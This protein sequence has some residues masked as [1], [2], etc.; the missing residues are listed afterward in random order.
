MEYLAQPNLL[1]EA[2]AY[3]GRETSGRSWA[4]IEQRL[5]QHKAETSPAFQRDFAALKRATARIK[6]ELSRHPAPRPELF[7]DLEGFPF[8]TIGSSSI[9]FLLFYPM[10]DRYDGDPMAVAEAVSALA[11]EQ[12]AGNLLDTLDIAGDRTEGDAVSGA[13]LMDTVLSLSVPDQSKITI[14]HIY[15]NYPAL[16]R[17]TAAAMAPLLELLEREMPT[18]LEMTAAFEADMRAI[19]RED[20]FGHLTHLKP[21]PEVDYLIRPFIF[22]MDTNLTFN[23]APNSVHFYCGFLRKELLH[24]ISAQSSHSDDVYASYRLLGDRT[25]FDILCYLRDHVAYGQELSDRF[26]LSR[27]TIHHHMNKLVDAGLVSCTV[28]GNRVYYSLDREAV[29]TFLRSQETLFAGE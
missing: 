27:N 22:G 15:R 28:S 19:S 1:L 4:H 3:Y 21:A 5:R 13:D 11:P 14:L 16:A 24:V 2:L 9:A 6:K 17:E 8:S 23:V 10:L 12:L 18:L 20:F 29:K 26:G 25:R 7:T